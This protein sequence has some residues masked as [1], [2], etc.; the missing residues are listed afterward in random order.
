M[1]TF[2]IALPVVGVVVFGFWYF[3]SNSGDSAI[4]AEAARQAAAAIVSAPATTIDAP[5]PV[6]VDTV[7]PSA[8]D[9]ATVVPSQAAVDT[10]Q[11]PA[12]PQQEEKKITSATFHTNKGDFSVEFFGND[13]PN[14]VANFIKLAKSGFYDGTKFHRV[15]KGFMI[16]GGDPFSKD[17]SAQDKWG[18]GGPG[19]MFADE[20]R[21]NNHN[22]AGTLA[23]A[24]SGPNT[25]GSQFFI[26][27]NN[28]NYLDGKHTV[29]G[30]LTGGVGVVQAIE[31]SP[32]GAND[33]P[34][35]PVVVTGI[36]LQ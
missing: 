4:Q 17:D 34:L 31:N 8:P 7:V 16:Q 25:N 26:N 13:A 19:Y 3:S 23:M 20:L 32:T 27:V 10:P 5:A 11:Q 22:D 35:E 30:R 33:R 6:A 24:N 15:I 12:A 2:L 36:T 18:R 29:F 14:T 1:K 21:A 9:A 28:N